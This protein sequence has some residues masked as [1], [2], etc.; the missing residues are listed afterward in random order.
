MKNLKILF[1]LL[2]I[3]S[4]LFSQ[5]DID[6]VIPSSPTVSELGKYGSMP[7][8]YYAGTPQ[9]NIPLYNFE[10]GDFDLPISLSYHASG[11]K[12]DEVASWVG[13]GWSLNAG[14]VISIQVKNESDFNKNRFNILDFDDIENGMRPTTQEIESMTAPPQH[15]GIDSEPDIYNFNFCGYSGQF[16]FDEEMN[17]HFLNDQGNLNLA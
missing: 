10:V 6:D 16:V 5:Y 15:G 7:I 1:V 17:A 11:I 3:S 12:V 13:L 4:R 14:G 8:S 2:F 9:I